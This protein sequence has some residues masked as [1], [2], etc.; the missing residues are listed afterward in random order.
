MQACVGSGTTPGHQVCLAVR[1]GSHATALLFRLSA[2][3]SHSGA[4][5]HANNVDPKALMRKTT[6]QR[7][8]QKV[9][10]TPEMAEHVSHAATMEEIVKAYQYVWQLAV[11]AHKCIAFLGLPYTSKEYIHTHNIMSGELWAYQ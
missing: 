5:T 3:P 2:V 10:D 1:L 6:L 11:A 4:D 9:L 8:L 7:G